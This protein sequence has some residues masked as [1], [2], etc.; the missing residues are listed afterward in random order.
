MI[1]IHKFFDEKQQKIVHKVYV[2]TMSHSLLRTLPTD[3]WC[4]MLESLEIERKYG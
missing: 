1:K 3:P 4:S 2:S